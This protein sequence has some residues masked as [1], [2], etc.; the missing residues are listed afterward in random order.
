MIKSFLIGSLATLSFVCVTTTS[1]KAQ[2]G[3]SYQSNLTP[4]QLISLARQGRF[5]AQGIPG[6]SRFGSAV[7]SGKVDAETLIAS[8]IA[9]D[10]LSPTALQNKSY[11][12]GVK[13]HLRSGGCS[14]S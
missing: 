5:K 3:E 12:A 8:A 13:N 4:R 10:K 9:Q 14:S 6:Y 11:I 2:S 1:V 7:R